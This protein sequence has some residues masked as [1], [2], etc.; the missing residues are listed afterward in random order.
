METL[1]TAWR[2]SWLGYV[3][4][5]SILKMGTALLCSVLGASCTLTR[6]LLQGKGGA[7]INFSQMTED[8][9]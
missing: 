7:V 5:T 1:E 8:T 2:Q 3:R 4:A 9:K 6:N